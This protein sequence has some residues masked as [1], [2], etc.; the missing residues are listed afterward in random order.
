MGK[1]SCNIAG[2]WLLSVYRI[3]ERGREINDEKLG[4][5]RAIM[6]TGG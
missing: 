6:E 3:G 2:L 4:E 1:L 5:K